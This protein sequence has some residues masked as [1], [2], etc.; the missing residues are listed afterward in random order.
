MTN[1]TRPRIVCLPDTAH[2]DPSADV[3]FPEA[4]LILDFGLILRGRNSQST[5]LV[6]QMGAEDHNKCIKCGIKTAS[7]YLIE[8]QQI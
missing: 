4:L 1:D 2:S 8:V 7:L 3:A 5:S 6:W